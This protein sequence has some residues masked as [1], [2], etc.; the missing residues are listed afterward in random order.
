MGRN[1]GRSDR[2]VI[3]GAELE[4]AARLAYEAGALLL[5]L[6]H[7]GL[8]VRHKDGG[9]IVTSADLAADAM[10][11]AGLAAA[12]PGDALVSEEAPAAGERLAS[13]RVWIVDPVD[14]TREFAAGGDAFAV[15][16]GLA[17]GGEAV[18]GAICAPAR[19]EL[20]TG[21]VGAGVSLNDTPAH[22]S[23]VDSL[24]DARI[25]VSSTEWRAGLDR[26]RLPFV[27]APLSSAAYKLARVAAGLDDGTFASWARRDWDICAGVALVRAGG[28]RVTLLDGGELR[29]NRATLLQPMGLVAAGA[30][31]HEVLRTAIA[32][33][34]RR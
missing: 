13:P 18:L 31:L 17:M 25:T 2:H 28:G 7:G 30:A 24:A 9:E 26:V 16:I 32:P 23:T 20:F 1:P 4:V 19:G 10:I 6:R 11:R 34:V 3:L 8:D 27:A 21:A 33:L 29:F 15:S 14:A 12:F 5:R 22:V